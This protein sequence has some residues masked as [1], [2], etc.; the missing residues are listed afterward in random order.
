MKKL[1]LVLIVVAALAAA[2][3]ATAAVF[4]LLRTTTVHRGGVVRLVGYAH[5]LPLYVLPAA[6][7]PCARTNACTAPIH[8]ASPP[9][10]PY[11]LIGRAPAE[12]GARAFRLRLP[13][14]V[15]PGRYKVFVWCKR[16]GGSLL[17]A[18]SDDSGQTLH[19]IR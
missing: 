6:R 7:Y 2:A 8:R 14:A 13:E 17:I 18:G 19:V 12:S 11:I 15:R 10:L 9:K 4:V 16:C 3:S 5:R 1:A